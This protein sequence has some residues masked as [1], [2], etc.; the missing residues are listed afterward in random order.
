MF[1][2]LKA[3]LLG[4]STGLVCMATCA[5]ALIPVLIGEKSATTHNR[6]QA[7]VYFLSGRLIAYMLVGVLASLLGQTFLP[8]ISGRL[9][10]IIFI[11][12]GLLLVLFAV[13]NGFPHLSFCHLIASHWP[14]RHVPLITGLLL[15]LSPCP[16]FIAAI[17]DVVLNGHVFYGVLFFLTFF[18]TTSLFLIPFAVFGLLSRYEEI[19]KIG[20]LSALISGIIYLM[21]GLVSTV[22]G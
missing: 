7:F 2:F 8:R 4:L 16:P 1:V 20:Q 3:G 11:C 10:G 15:G 19:V 22:A 21:M 5:P 18:V 12:L 13:M 17:T 6:Y 14:G 9:N